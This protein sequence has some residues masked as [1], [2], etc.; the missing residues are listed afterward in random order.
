MLKSYR[1]VVVM[2]HE[3]LV[4]AQGPLVLGFW[5]WGLGVR[6]HGLTTRKTCSFIYF[7]GQLLTD[8]QI[9]S[10]SLGCVSGMCHPPI[11][12]TF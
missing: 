7:N 8:E 2:A 6:G 9:Y 4:S 10:N 3:I 1:V 12:L 5:V 11:S